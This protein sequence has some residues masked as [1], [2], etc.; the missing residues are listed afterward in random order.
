MSNSTSVASV[1]YTLIA[2]FVPAGTM[3]AFA[4]TEPVY[5]FIV[6]ALGRAWPVSQV[7]KIPSFG[8]RGTAVKLS[9]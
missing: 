7:M 4:T 2:P 1:T 3:A 8:S 5:E 9:E 6:E